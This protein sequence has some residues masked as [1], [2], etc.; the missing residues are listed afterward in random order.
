MHC[1]HSLSRCSV[2]FLLLAA[3]SGCSRSG[4]APEKSASA[5]QVEQAGKQASAKD[6]GEELRAAEQMQLAPGGALG[7]SVAPSPV[8]AR[9]YAAASSPA[10]DMAVDSRA[11][12][13]QSRTLD[14]NARY[15]STYR[16]GNASAAAFDAAVAKGD[17][18]ASYKDLVGDIGSGYATGVEAPKETA[19]VAE[20]LL[21]R[22][23][24]G[25]RGGDTNLRVALRS[26]LAT[27]ARAPLSIHLVLDVSGSMRG[28]AMDNAKKAADA[29]VDKLDAGD[30]FSLTTFS[31]DAKT[32]VRDAAVGP[33]RAAIHKTIANVEADGG[34]NISSGLDA[35]YAQA[36]AAHVHDD[37]VKVVLLLS[38]GH[39]NGGDAS[40]T[41][42][43]DRSAKALAEGI[44]TSTFGLGGSFDAQIMSS[45]AD[46]GAGGYY[47]LADSTQIAKALQTELD[48]RLLPVAQAVELRV[49]LAPEID[50]VHVFG[51]HALGAQEEYRVRAQE[52][53]ID[54]NVQNRDKIAADRQ[55]DAAGGM[56]FFIPSFARDDRHATVMTLALPPGVGER[57]LGTIELRYKDRLSKKNVTV[58]IPLKATYALSDAES[59]ATLNKSVAATVQ[60]YAAGETA[61]NAAQWV[62]RGDRAQA[63]RALHE[64]AELL[65]SAAISLGE[66]R[67]NDEA[68]R[69]ARLEAATTGSE[70]VKDALPLA[71]LLRGSAYGYMQ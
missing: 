12:Q 70:S 19:L 39:A 63:T 43:M 55:S 64:R 59:G 9:A 31:T 53:A 14:R 33:N 42:L 44:Q 46:Q 25:P 38:D 1:I 40:V 5:S 54:R 57:R 69:L 10:H 61:L 13:P 4:S 41:G 51:S 35:G 24:V 36:R 15:A 48:S 6:K 58:E 2:T 16:P 26:T 20:V 30:D 60:A 49:R 22:G 68:R 18:S 56:R 17:I 62:D 47:Y 8:A 65:K 34:T 67:L 52:V 3:A 27:P 11:P 7:N 21:E 71:V 45:V 29:L 66:P 28:D 50:A 37:A 23:K 32:I